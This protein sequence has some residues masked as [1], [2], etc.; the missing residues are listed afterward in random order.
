[1]NVIT[2]LS[3]H[4]ATYKSS[5]NEKQLSRSIAERDCQ[6][7]ELTSRVSELTEELEKEK[8]SNRVL[9]HEVKKLCEVLERDRERVYAEIKAFGTRIEEANDNVNTIIG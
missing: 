2:R 9:E 8:S 1:M 7:S 6:I 4:W 5:K 3:R